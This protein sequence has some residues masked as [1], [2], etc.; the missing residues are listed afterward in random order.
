M[1]NG[2]SRNT[3]EMGNPHPRPR[4]S[5]ILVGFNQRALQARSQL[6]WPVSL[7]LGLRSR[8]DRVIE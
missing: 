3:P 6:T 8:W 2:R 7:R 5:G 1:R 4:L